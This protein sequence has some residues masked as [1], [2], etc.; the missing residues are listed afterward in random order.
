MGDGGLDLLRRGDKIIL[1]F[2][3]APDQRAS[4][5]LLALFMGG[6]V[7]ALLYAAVYAILHADPAKSAL[8]VPFLVGCAGFAVWNG[9]DPLLEPDYT[10]VFDPAARTVT[11]T[12][13]AW[14]SRTR[15]PVLFD[16]IKA[17]DTRVGYAARRRS[18]IV[19]LKLRNGEEWRLGY[20]AIWVRP[21]TASQFRPLIAKLRAELNL[22]GEDID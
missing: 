8:A 14:S 6:L 15:G 13:S 12:E 4:A 21:A 20:D 17:L 16:D 9:T 3:R 18:V 5:T 19:W 1:V 7:V 10:T 22:G 2:E 11:L